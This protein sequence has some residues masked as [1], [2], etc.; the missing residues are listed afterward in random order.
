MDSES[1]VTQFRENVGTAEAAAVVRVL[2]HGS[3]DCSVSWLSC[4]T[5]PWFYISNESVFLLQ[6]NVLVSL[7]R[8]VGEYNPKVRLC[9]GHRTCVFVGL[10]MLL[11]ALN[12]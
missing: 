3:A 8:V 7:R 9:L 12:F 4:V 1:N 5:V 10:V 6:R 2:L 11:L